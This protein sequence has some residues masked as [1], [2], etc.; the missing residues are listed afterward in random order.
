MSLPP[1][2]AITSAPSVPVNA[3]S[4][5]L[6][7][8]VAAT[9]AHDATSNTYAEPAS[10]P[11]A[12]SSKAPPPSRC[13]PKP[14]ARSRNSRRW[15][16]RRRSAWP[17][18]PTCPPSA[19]THTPSPRGC[20]RPC[21]HHRGVAR[22]RH[23]G[24]ELVV[25]GGV[26]GGQLGLLRPRAPRAHEHVRRPASVPGEGVVGDCSD[27]RVRPQPPSSTRTRQGGAVG[28]GQLG[29]LRPGDPRAHEHIRRARISPGEGIV[30]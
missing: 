21:S 26:G 25:G 29:L 1:R 5:P 8:I 19:R 22:D 9:P 10:S 13:H 7:D 3:S 24:P 16:H 15:R 20:R 2:P 14:P 12:V 27:H 6:P 18:A 4:P 28:G 11:A 17:A 30:E 23:R